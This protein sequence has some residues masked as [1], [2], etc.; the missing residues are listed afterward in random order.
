VIAID[1]NQTQKQTQSIETLALVKQTCQQIPIATPQ[2]P[3]FA[4][5]CN[6]T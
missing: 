4:I 1:C 3:L 5:D 2:S 6:D